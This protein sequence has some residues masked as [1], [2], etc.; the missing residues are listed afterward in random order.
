MT[1]I[2]LKMEIEAARMRRESIQ[3]QIDE[4]GSSP[5]LEEFLVD[6]DAELLRL[7]R[8]KPDDRPTPP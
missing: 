6:C 8:I 7:F 4:R 1:R 2:Q 5:A 3:R